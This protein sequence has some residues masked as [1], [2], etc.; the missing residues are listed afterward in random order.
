MIDSYRLISNFTIK[1]RTAISKVLVIFIFLISPYSF[2]FNIVIRAQ[3]S[4]ITGS[5]AAIIVKS[6][7]NKISNIQNNISKNSKI[8]KDFKDTVIDENVVVTGYRNTSHRFFT[9]ATASVKMAEIKM[10]AV[11]DISRMLE[12]RIPGLSIQNVSGSFGSAPRINIR[13]GASLVGSVQPLWVIDG[14]VY[15][16]LITLNP[17]QLVSGDPSTLISSAVSGLNP[18]DIKEIQVLKDASATSL[19]GA[20]ALNGVIVITTKQGNLNSPIRVEYRF[21]QSYRPIPS[22]KNFDLLDASASLDIYREMEAK[23]YFKLE[24][25]IYG[26]RGGIYHQMYHDIMNTNDDGKFILTNTPQARKAYLN[27]NGN[28]NTNWF[29]TLFKISPIQSHTINLSGGGDKIATYLSLG[30]YQDPGWTIADQVQKFTGNLKTNF[31]FNQ[32]FRTTLILQ[33]N[34]RDQEAPGSFTRRP[35]PALGSF[36]RDFD[37]NPFAYALGTSRTLRVKDDNKLSYYRNNWAPFNILN[38]YANNNMHIS[39]LDFRIQAQAVYEIIKDF[40]ISALASVRQV[41]NTIS[42]NITDKSNVV[43]AFRAA[44]NPMVQAENIYLYTNRD[45]PDLPKKVALE[46]GGIFNKT[47][48]SLR[49]YLARLSLDYKKN[50]GDHNIN[51]FSFVELRNVNRINNPL[52]FQYLN[53]RNAS[54]FALNNRQDRGITASLSTIYRYK[55]RYIFTG[56]FN[57]EGS[58]ATGIKSPSQFLPTWN[59]GLKWILDKEKFLNLPDYIN[60][61]SIRASYG[62]TAKINENALNFNPVFR[63]ATTNR[64]R[65]QDRENQLLIQGLENRDLTWEKMYEFNLG[66]DLG[67]LHNNITLVLDLY[68]RNSFDLI[69][70]VRN[71]GIGGQYYKYANVGNLRTRGIEI[72][73]RTHNLSYNKFRWNSS[74]SASYMQQKITKLSSLPNAFDMVSGTGKGNVEGLPRGSLFSFNFQ[75]LNQYGL[76]TFD[77]GLYPSNGYP[78]GNIYSADFSDAQYTKTYLIYHGSTEPNTILGLSNT[79]IYQSLELSIFITAQLGSKIRLN[80]SF[81][82]NFADLN[83][84]SREYKNRWLK[85]GDELQTRVPTIPSQDIIS[86][87]GQE[88]TSRAYNTYNYSQERVADG[89]FVR[90]KTITLSYILP[91]INYLKFLKIKTFKV[92]FQVLNSFLIYSDK[93]LKG[94]DPEFYRSGGVSLPVP[95]QYTLTLNLGF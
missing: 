32:K 78:N 1:L 79:F 20:R 22:Y 62:L 43:Q 23:G 59:L 58:N 70:F 67:L 7:P 46:N 56:I 42:H 6:K 53:N 19:Y 39:L 77:F 16:N 57:F 95:K 64:S 61:W 52:I 50:L 49:S 41:N 94:Q 76:P 10:D 72:A 31:H 47:E 83:V 88:R 84:F 44:D 91:E 15:E 73:L 92:S 81:D 9:G 55:N 74:I 11:P 75:G 89:S 90:M 86:A 65:A 25:A 33:G 36:E 66:M 34:I 37:I 13:G 48:N 8:N 26:R 85:A 3:E 82:P 54:Y 93:K 12:G 80:P 60:T 17:D 27:T 29:N 35:N 24:D 63:G 71:S 68:Q 28:G 45:E 18:S 14:V 2:K 38:E 40:E 21:E 51:I 30:Y 87:L 69:D 5:R 4:A